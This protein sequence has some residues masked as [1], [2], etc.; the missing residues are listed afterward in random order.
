MAKTP[1]PAPFTQTP[2]KQDP[3]LPDA[4]SD[5]VEQDPILGWD[6]W[7]KSPSHVKMNTSMI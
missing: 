5:G 7:Q 1:T 2:T 4:A 6:K 3:S